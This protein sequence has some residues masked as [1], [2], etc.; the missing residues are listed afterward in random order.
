MDATIVDCDLLE[1]AKENV[2]P[3]ASGRRVTALTDVLGTP[4]ALRDVALS[5]ERDR[6]RAVVRRALED[7]EEEEEEEGDGERFSSPL[8][9]YNEFVTW[10]LEH[11][12]QGHSA[13]SGLLELLEEATRLLKDREGGRYRRELRYLKLWILY[14]S[15]VEKPILVF[16]FLLANDI[17]TE[18]A[19]L[20]EEFAM[21]LE[22]NGR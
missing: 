14:S 1:A 22:R 5:R 3:L 2:Q 11:Y 4:H 10:T 15:F 18:W 21:V 9:A 6:W 7:E 19:A 12:P 16:R 8:E 13:E 20:Y 17:G